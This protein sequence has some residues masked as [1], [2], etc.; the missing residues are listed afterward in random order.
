ME[1]AGAIPVISSTSGFSMR[2]RNCRAYAESDSIY[3][4]CPSAYSVSKARLDFPDP[5][6][7]VT[8]VIALWGIVTSI[9]FRLWTRAPRTRISSVSLPSCSVRRA[10]DSPAPPLDWAIN[11][12]RADR[13]AIS[14]ALPG[15]DFSVDFV[16]M[17]INQKLY[18]P[19]R[20]R[21]NKPSRRQ[22]PFRSRHC[23]RIGPELP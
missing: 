19:R 11:L 3:R 7:P 15:A 10:A 1:I 2:S 8:T 5:E 4:R 23:L 21:A 12:R 16:A 14:S 13:R 9:F 6:T 17:G 20:R 22:N 18:A